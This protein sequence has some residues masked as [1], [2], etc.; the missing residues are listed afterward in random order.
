[1]SIA[2]DNSPDSRTVGSS[3]TRREL[4]ILNIFAN[5]HSSKEVADLLFVSKRTVDFHMANLYSKL[6]VCNRVQA[7]LAAARLGF[8]PAMESFGAA[9]I[10]VDD[11][12]QKQA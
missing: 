11:S 5:G 9:R 6:G 2:I 4:E 10:I 8:L 3:I 12:E 1:M 7:M